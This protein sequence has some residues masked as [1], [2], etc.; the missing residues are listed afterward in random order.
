MYR[1]FVGALAL[2]PLSTIALA[3]DIAPP[4][5]ASSDAD[6]QSTIIVTAA[7]TQLPASALPLTVDI[8]DSE[9]L[10][11]QGFQALDEAIVRAL[12]ELKSL[13]QRALDAEGG[14]P[15]LRNSSRASSPC[16]SSYG[17]R[18]GRNS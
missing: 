10:E 6:E 3:Q 4:D 1:Y 7:R 12:D 2:A 17:M 14:E 18:N 15:S 11:R 13:R 8:I 5:A 16:D 9:A